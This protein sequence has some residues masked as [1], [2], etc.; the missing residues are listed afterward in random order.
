MTGR[1]AARG[2]YRTAREVER[3]DLA[4]IEELLR[5]DEP[6]P[7]RMTMPQRPIGWLLANAVFSAIVALSGYLLLRLIGYAVPYPLLFTAM[8]AAVLL[9]RA[10]T[11][12]RP[13]PLP[14]AMTGTLPATALPPDPDAASRADGL[15]QAL[16]RWANRME[17]TERDSGR[18]EQVVR[19][20]VADLT[21]ER[22]RQRHGLTRTSDPARA[23][24]LTGELLWTFLHGQIARI[25]TPAE[26]AAVVKDLE[27]I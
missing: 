8:F 26:M 16:S 23:R 13:R 3:G 4:T 22:L 12:V 24:E 19:D 10:L 6:A 27:E 18:F 15:Y 2:G 11:A 25:P 1:H 20:R 17:W 7:P 5:A 9:R 21:D 14:P